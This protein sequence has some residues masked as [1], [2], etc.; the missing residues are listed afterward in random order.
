MHILL[1]SYRLLLHISPGTHGSL[2]QMRLSSGWWI[3]FCTVWNCVSTPKKQSCH[4]FLRLLRA[5][6]HQIRMWRHVQKNTFLLWNLDAK[7]VY[8]CAQRFCVYSMSR[9]DGLL[10][11]TLDSHCSTL[12]TKFS[13]HLCAQQKHAMQT[14]VVRENRK[15]CLKT[16]TPCTTSNKFENVKVLP[17]FCW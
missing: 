6:S 13:G 14:R 7:L 12:A 9:D 11:K 5:L 16:Q 8:V 4:G 1:D 10:D 15:R 3:Y 2:H 17:Y